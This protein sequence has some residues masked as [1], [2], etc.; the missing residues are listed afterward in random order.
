MLVR[1]IVI[2]V[3]VLFLW[4]SNIFNK[5]TTVASIAV[6]AVAAIGTTVFRNALQGGGKRPRAASEPSFARDWKRFLTVP[7]KDK[8]QTLDLLA[9]DHQ[10]RHLQRLRTDPRHSGEPEHTWS[11]NEDAMRA[12]KPR[13]SRY[14]KRTKRQMH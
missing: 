2:V 12:A 4:A 6:V 7:R 8:Q 1:L 13:T 9:R 10:T 11:L 3:A 14:S 5:H